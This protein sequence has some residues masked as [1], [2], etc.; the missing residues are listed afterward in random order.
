MAA[1]PPMAA[2]QKESNLAR[3]L[4]SGTFAAAAAMGSMAWL[5]TFCVLVGSAG[6][7]ELAV[8]HPVRSLGDCDSGAAE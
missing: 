1:S 5:L 4:G 8:F 6:I 2:S 7:A 3:V